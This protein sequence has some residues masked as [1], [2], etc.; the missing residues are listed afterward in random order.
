MTEHE[1][2]IILHSLTHLGYPSNEA[3]KLI[4]EARSIVWQ[5]GVKLLKEEE[6]KDD[7]THK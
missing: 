4:Q 3:K 1:A 2:L 7:E 5:A 6:Q